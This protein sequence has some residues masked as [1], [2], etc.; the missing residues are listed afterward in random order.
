[1]VIFFGVCWKITFLIF[2]GCSFPF[3]VGVFHLFSF[4]GL[5]LWKDIVWVFVFVC[6]G[7]YFLS[8]NILV[9]PLL[10]ESFTGYSSLG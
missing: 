8:W 9:S 3:G 6:F 2:L 5:D 7:G 4:E 1:V 10:I